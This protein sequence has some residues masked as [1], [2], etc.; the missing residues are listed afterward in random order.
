MG[1]GVEDEDMGWA[2]IQSKKI[3]HMPNSKVTRERGMLR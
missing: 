1:M 3:K 2:L